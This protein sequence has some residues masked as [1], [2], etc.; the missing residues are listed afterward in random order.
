M[1]VDGVFYPSL[2]LPLTVGEDVVDEV[3]DVQ[4]VVEGRARDG[5]CH[6]SA[7]KQVI[8]LWGLAVM[9]DPVLASLDI[10]LRT[11]LHEQLEMIHEVGDIPGS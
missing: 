2:L 4:L 7:C 8:L 9:H 6:Q 5:D 11:V 3:D 1:W 10:R